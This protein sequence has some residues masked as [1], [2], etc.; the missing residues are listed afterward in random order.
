MLCLAVVFPLLEH[1]VASNHKHKRNTGNG[2]SISHNPTRDQGVL[3]L[4]II[5]VCGGVIVVI[6]VI[7]VASDSGVV[8]SS[9]S[10]VVSTRDVD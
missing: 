1:S 3:I 7:I 9:Y 2:K 4:G 8:I 5:A 6:V 10:V